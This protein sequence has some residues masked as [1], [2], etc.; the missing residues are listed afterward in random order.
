MELNYVLIKK[1][2]TKS[3]TNLLKKYNELLIEQYIGG[4]EIQ[5]AVINKKALGAIELVPK[6]LFYDYQS[7][8]TPRLQKLNT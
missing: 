4:Q 5:V 7:K 2:L 3:L 8:Y 1:E 6:R